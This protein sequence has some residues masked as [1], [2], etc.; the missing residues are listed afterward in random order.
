MPRSQAAPDGTELAFDANGDGV[1]V[2][3]ADGSDRRRLTT[4]RDHPD[5]S[6]NG[7]TILYTG[8]SNELWL[9]NADGSSARPLLHPPY[10]QG[11]DPRDTADRGSDGLTRVRRVSRVPNRVPDGANLT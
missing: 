9:M 10:A 1:Y 11:L 8:P 3:N 6:P 7:N 4:T 5:W 2:A